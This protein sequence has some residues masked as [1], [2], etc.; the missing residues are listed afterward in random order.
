[1]GQPKKVSKMGL[2]IVSPEQIG[3]KNG[4]VYFKSTPNWFEIS[5]DMGGFLSFI[6]SVSKVL[7][8]ELPPPTP[9]CKWCIYRTYFEPKQEL[10]VEDLPF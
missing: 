8:G 10:N 3:F 6:G 1:M 7:N 4:F 2:I 5:E 9:E